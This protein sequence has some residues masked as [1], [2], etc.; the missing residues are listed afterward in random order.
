MMEYSL[1]CTLIKRQ[2]SELTANSWRICTIH[3]AYEKDH[4]YNSQGNGTYPSNL[5]DYTIRKD[6]VSQIHSFNN[7]FL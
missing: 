5:P 3:A 1:N 2:F 7:V 4:L 6:C